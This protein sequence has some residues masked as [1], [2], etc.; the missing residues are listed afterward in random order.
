MKLKIANMAVRIAL[1]AAVI[2]Q[3]GYGVTRGQANS[4]ASLQHYPD[5]VLRVTDAASG[6]TVTV[7]P[8]GATLQATGRDGT[9]LWAVDVIAETGK[10]RTGFAVVRHVGLAKPGIV[11]V[12]VGKARSVD[13]DL[14][15][16]RATVVG[17]G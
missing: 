3:G 16:G 11:S 13:I 14:K 4:H 9:V 2:T 17:E 1:G 7:D 8:D 10:P 12:L 15:T 6:L 5:A